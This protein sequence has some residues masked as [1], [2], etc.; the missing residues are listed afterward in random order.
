MTTKLAEWLAAFGTIGLGIIAAFQDRIRSLIWKPKLVVSIKTSPPDCHKTILVSHN[1]QGNTIESEC[2]YFRLCMKNIGKCG[3]DR[4][5]IMASKLFMLKNENTSVMINSFI[6]QNIRTSFSHTS[7]YETISPGIEKYFD[8]GHIINP[9]KR[10]QFSGEDIPE[11]PFPPT[12]TIFSV[13]FRSRPFNMCHLIDPGIY[14]MEIV[15]GASN[16]P[17]PHMFVLQISH[18]SWFED[19]QEMFQKGINIKILP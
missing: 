3:A 14:R 12:S 18:D 17:K 16:I 8:L 5:E 4:V 9:I 7:F 6:P 13:D 19:E 10:S 15:V 1:R 11:R 2:Y